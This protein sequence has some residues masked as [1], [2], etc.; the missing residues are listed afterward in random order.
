MKLAVK[1]STKQL[2]QIRL[3]GELP[4]NNTHILFKVQTM[5]KEDGEKGESPMN[6]KRK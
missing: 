6:I 2:I 3:A 5:P 1:Q 4:A